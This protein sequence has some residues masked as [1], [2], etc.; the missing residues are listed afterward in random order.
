MI[1][2]I[3]I[4]IIKIIFNINPSIGLKYYTKKF[5]SQFGNLVYLDNTE[6]LSLYV[7]TMYIDKTLIMTCREYF[8][9]YYFLKRVEEIKGDIA[10]VGV[11]KG[12][13]AKLLAKL[14]GNKHLF[15][16]DTFSGMPETNKKIDFHNKGEFA[17]TNVNIVK[18]YIG[19]NENV[20]FIK[21]FF[22]DST[23]QLVEENPTF[24]FVNLDVDIYQSTLDG[25]H[26]FYPKLTKGG[27]I[28]S[29]DYNSIS[30]PGV[31]LAFD[32]FFKSKPET[33]IPIWDSQCIV[34]KL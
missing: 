10:E 27:I 1:N 22:P 16:F 24:S 26:Y 15:L 23:K 11:Y 3:K 20:H 18:Q 32:E 28:I 14:K 4:F 2:K 33:V 9:L 13:S 21:G 6:L 8:N 30:C 5:K 7:N 29:H 12:G 17:D 34:F 19:D 25:L 31:K